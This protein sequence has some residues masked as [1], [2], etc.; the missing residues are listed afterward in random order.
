M[1]IPYSLISGCPAL[2]TCYIRSIQT[3]RDCFPRYG[4]ISSFREKSVI[5]RRS[6][7]DISVLTTII[8]S[9]R[10]IALS[11]S[12]SL[13]TNGFKQRSTLLDKE[14][15]LELNRNCANSPFVSFMFCSCHA[16]ARNHA[17]GTARNCGTQLRENAQP[18]GI[19]NEI[20]NRFV[21]FDGIELSRLE[22]ANLLINWKIRRQNS[23]VTAYCTP[24]LMI[25][26]VLGNCKIINIIDVIEIYIY[27]HAIYFTR[28]IHSKFKKNT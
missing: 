19:V 28:V 6:R 18:G 2:A 10:V 20:R 8:E 27:R 9:T 24:P 17:A 25:Y 26:L 12:N 13:W 16:C 14:T 11:K 5:R 3:M 15:W 4:L 1:V 21:I 7:A 23:R 22:C